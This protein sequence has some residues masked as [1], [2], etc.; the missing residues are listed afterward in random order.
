MRMFA[1][2]GRR[3]KC[4]IPACCRGGSYHGLDQCLLSQPG[5][6]MH[7][8]NTSSHNDRQLTLVSSSK[9]LRVT[10]AQVLTY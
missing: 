6:M 9:R 4:S 7:P 1:L 8:C 10:G 2:G 5:S 3:A